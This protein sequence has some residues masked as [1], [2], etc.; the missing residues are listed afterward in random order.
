M[1]ALEQAHTQPFGLEAACAIERLLRLHVALHALPV[2]FPHRYGKRH[3]IDLALP[4]GG[5]QQCHPGQEGD[6][7]SA[8]LQQLFAGALETVRFAQNLLAQ[9]RDLIGAYDQV[10]RMAAGQCLGLLPGQASHQL[11]GGFVSEPPL[12]QVGACPGEGQAQAREQFAPVRGAGS[13]QQ[14]QH[15]RLLIS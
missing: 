14:R 4:C 12:V 2:Q 3:A 7:L 13:Q 1:G 11:C 9:Y 6:V 5:V 8:G 10:L 15:G